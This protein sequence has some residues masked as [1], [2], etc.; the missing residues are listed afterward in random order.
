MIDDSR[1]HDGARRAHH[2]MT[3][4]PSAE[5]SALPVAS[6]IE[7]VRRVPAI[8]DAL[9][10]LPALL[11]VVE[12]TSR[13]GAATETLIE[14]LIEAIDDEQDSVTAIAAIHA[15]AG[16]PGTA[17]E[18]ALLE[19]VLEGPPGYEDHALWVARQ[20]TPSTRL[21][22]AA[23]RAVSLGAMPGMHAQRT[24]TSWSR[25][26]PDLVLEAL[27]EALQEHHTE[28]ARRHLV[29]TVGLVPGPR[30]RLVLERTAL[31]HNELGAV[32]RTAV[33]AF[34]DRIHE[35]LPARI[36]G[37][38]SEGG[39]VGREVRTARSQRRLLGRGPRRGPRPSL[40]LRVAQLHLGRA[41][42][43]STFLPQLG[44]ALSE[45]GDVTETLTI[46]RVDA[47]DPRPA[48]VAPHGHRVERIELAAGDG[49]TFG[50]GWPALV[51][52][53]RGIRAALLAGVTPHVMHL[54]MADP[55]SFA[56][57]AV[58]RQLGIPLVFTLA[59]DP[60][61]PIAAAEAS[62]ALDRRGFAGV[63]ARDA[64]W[65][66]ASL[67]EQLARRARHLVLFPR[68]QVRP[69][70]TSLTGID[71]TSGNTPA[72]VV[73]EGI[74]IGRVDAAARE[75]THAS[76]N[77]PVLSDLGTAVARLP[78]ERHGL[79]LLV[80]VGRLHPVKGM[81]RLVAAYLSDPD[82]AARANLVIVG[83]DLH[84]PSSAEAAE[85][86]RIDRTLASHAQRRD[87]VIL[88][89]RR[90]SEE[91]ALVLAA[92]QRGWGGLVGAAGAYVCASAKEEFGLAVAEALAAGLPVTAPQVG[93]PATYVEDGV[94]GA[95]VDTTDTEALAA[96]A[97][98]ALDL[99]TR[100][101]TA[102]LGRALVDERYTL[103]QMARSLEEVY[104]VTV[105][106]RTPIAA[107]PSGGRS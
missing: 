67:V 55:G 59:P 105:D 38:A 77:P 72:T 28:A 71:V 16:V 48:T 44:V 45:L 9:H 10:E 53:A 5:R 47:S 30:A 63:D 14:P 4:L 17:A 26:A 104:R 22:R 42:G 36:A 96:G 8:L 56:G 93:G 94:T 6:A 97:R 100:P 11:A 65:F 74:D 57:A 66:R 50:T 84:D 29:E 27:E 102:A 90:S 95:L 13:E 69:R 86:A 31:D 107:A 1:I 81:S 98:R 40:G 43:L 54:R 19:L 101:Q 83:G 7:R 37:L 92:A 80:S 68:P 88:L 35:G 62:G 89:G 23:A 18:E 2:P 61:G 34:A 15:L 39:D 52:V 64:L 12:A 60:H 82:L 46:A 106:G 41:G 99:S 91:V 25:T 32:R 58:A 21:A 103:Q 85:L 24:L 70:I 87:Q 78:V 3:R 75:V 20:R 49:E 33:R 51:E 73:A 76:S 79:P